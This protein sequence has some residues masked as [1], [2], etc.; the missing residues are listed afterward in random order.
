ML[1]LIS[2]ILIAA[3]FG[4]LEHGFGNKR[5]K[6][7][8]RPQMLTDAALHLL[9]ATA[10]AGIN[11]VLISISAV[12][13]LVPTGVVTLEQLAAGEYRGFGPLAALPAG[14][15]FVMAFVIGDFFLY[16]SHRMF[17]GRSLWRFHSVHHSS[18]HLDWL[19]SVRGHPVNDIIGNLWLVIPFLLAGFDPVIAAV[20]GPLIGL[21]AL[22]GH[23]DVDW[24][25]GPLRLVFASPVFHRWHH[26]REP[27]A[28]DKNFASFLPVWDVLFGT[29]YLP[30]DRRPCHFGIAEPVRHT[31]FGLLAHPFRR[32][33]TGRASGGL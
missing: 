1:V 11:L 20:P 7:W 31:F 23:A 21:L 13:V 9:N 32:S 16:W 3:A 30:K 17:H 22:L 12:M 19:S 14:V 26:S 4:V 10:T 24:D 28:I 15:Q 27:E 6:S 5:G 18:E 25:W 2:I 8:R 33:S 29:L